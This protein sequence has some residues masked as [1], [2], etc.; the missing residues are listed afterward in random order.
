MNFTNV[1]INI[2]GNMYSFNFEYK[3]QT[4]YGQACFITSGGG[5]MIIDEDFA[6]IRNDF[7]DEWVPSIIAKLKQLLDFD[8]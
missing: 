1:P 4:E 3:E 2:D 7:P 8:V 6:I 5:E